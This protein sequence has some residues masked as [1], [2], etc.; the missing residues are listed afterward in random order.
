M[1]MDHML[2]TKVVE[3]GKACKLT[4]QICIV[5]SLAKQNKPI[6]PRW[7]ILI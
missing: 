5:G 7:D 6:K 3:M 2:L 1:E 4:L